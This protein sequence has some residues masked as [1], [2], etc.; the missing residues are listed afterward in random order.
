MFDD[1]DSFGSVEAK[2]QNSDSSA[3]HFNS[4]GGCI[5]DYHIPA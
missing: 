4:S 3:I 2:S 1:K 5:L